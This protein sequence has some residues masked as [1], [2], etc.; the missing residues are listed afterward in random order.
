[1]LYKNP[2]AILNGSYNSFYFTVCLEIQL[3]IDKEPLDEKGIGIYEYPTVRWNLGTCTSLN[4]DFENTT[5]NYESRFFE[6]CCLAPGK[7]I[8]SCHNN[9]PIRGWKDAFLIIGGHTYCD[10]FIGY[11]LLQHVVVTGTRV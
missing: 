10:N 3:Q 1:M 5:Y 4:S 9:I 7:N 11:K 2:I 6:R 8:L